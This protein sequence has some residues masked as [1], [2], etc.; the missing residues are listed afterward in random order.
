MGD[1]RAGEAKVAEHAAAILVAEFVALARATPTFSVGLSDGIWTALSR[2][3]VGDSFNQCR[4]TRL[5]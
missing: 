2:H 1:K 4:L 5:T 3:L